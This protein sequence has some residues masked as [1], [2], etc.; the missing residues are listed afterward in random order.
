MKRWIALLLMI[1]LLPCAALCGEAAA[2]AEAAEKEESPTLHDARYYFEHRMLPD[3]FYNNRDALVSY[4][5]R[6]GVFTLWER[7]CQNNGLDPTYEEDRFGV[8]EFPQEDGTEV[9]IL[10]LPKPED[11]TLC[12][13]IYLCWNPETGT[14]GYYTVEYDNLLGETWFLCGWTAN[15]T[16]M[17]YSIVSA[18]TDPEDPE[19][20]AALEKE[21]K[22]VL[23]LMASKK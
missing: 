18:V 19:Y 15:G 21:L 4:L 22:A 8:R 12:C 16:H 20:E 23:E 1:C 17:N 14:A 2:A 3:Y 6:N 5:R 9:M 10:T 7:F 13:R 11:M